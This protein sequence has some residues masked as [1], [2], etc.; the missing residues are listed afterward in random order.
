MS[1]AKQGAAGVTNFKPDGALFGIGPIGDDVPPC[2]CRPARYSDR[3]SR[4][5]AALDRFFSID[6]VPEKKDPSA[7]LHH[8]L[9]LDTRRLS[10]ESLILVNLSYLRSL[11]TRRHMHPHPSASSPNESPKGKDRGRFFNE[12]DYTW[13]HYFLLRRYCAGRAVDLHVPFLACKRRR[14]IQ[15]VAT[16]S[17][18]ICTAEQ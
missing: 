13:P 17:I 9:K 8:G 11:C 2:P 1:P 3:L 18:L 12:H 15:P 16:F 4:R 5:P 6:I 14:H 10:G 7:G